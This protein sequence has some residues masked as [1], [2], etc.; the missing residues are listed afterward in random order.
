[1]LR[2]DVLKLK[3]RNPL[4]AGLDDVLDAIGDLNVAV[5]TDVSDV[6]GV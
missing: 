5:G 6:V 2:D 4:A 3:R 1:V